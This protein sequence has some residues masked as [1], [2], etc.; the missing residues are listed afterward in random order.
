MLMLQRL[1][2]GRPYMLRR[3]GVQITSRLCTSELKDIT[4]TVNRIYAD[5]LLTGMQ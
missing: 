1:L 5:E 2:W 4:S 3:R